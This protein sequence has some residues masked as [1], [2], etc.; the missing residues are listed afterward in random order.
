[1]L[2]HSVWETTGTNQDVCLE[3]I[4]L[5]NGDDHQWLNVNERAKAWPSVEQTMEIVT[6]GL[7]T[8]LMKE[9]L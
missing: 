1:M 7:K 8:T 4:R 5:L 3:R 9:L 6:N 2:R